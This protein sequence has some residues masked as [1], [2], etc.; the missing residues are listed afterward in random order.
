M[1]TSVNE[2]IESMLWVRE[3]QNSV[4]ETWVTSVWRSGWPGPPAADPSIRTGPSHTGFFTD[5]ARVQSDMGSRV[6]LR[7]LEKLLRSRRERF[8]RQKSLKQ[9]LKFSSRKA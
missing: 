3:D 5:S 1:T 4:E 9:R 2:S 6:V 8:S 7:A